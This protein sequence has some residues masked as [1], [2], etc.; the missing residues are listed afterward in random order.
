MAEN[1][2]PSARAWFADKQ[3][4]Q[5]IVEEQNARTGFVPDPTATPEKAQAMTRALGIRPEENLLSCGIIAA[6]EE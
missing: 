6:R 3:A 4:I 2:R 5:K 1:S